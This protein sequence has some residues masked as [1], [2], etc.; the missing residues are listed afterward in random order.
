[1]PNRQTE[2]LGRESHRDVAPWHI[3]E[4]GT[5][6]S[7]S[8]FQ[9]T[10]NSWWSALLS[11]WAFLNWQA[12][13]SK[14][15]HLLHWVVKNLLFPPVRVGKLQILRHSKKPN[16]CTCRSRFR[17]LVKGELQ[18]DARENRLQ[19]LRQKRENFLFVVVGKMQMI[20]N[21]GT[22]DICHEIVRHQQHWPTKSLKPP[23][24]TSIHHPPVTFSKP[25][26][27]KSPSSTR[28]SPSQRCTFSV[29][30]TH[31]FRIVWRFHRLRLR[32]KGD[33]TAEFAAVTR[34]YELI[35]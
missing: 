11:F 33:K 32:W 31:D 20:S 1:M 8:D 17:N 4:P 34:S 35:N 10:G 12:K 18:G 23:L 22:L 27:L 25:L 7:F 9:S 24:C 19:H 3:R 29:K 21:L 2:S 13:S 5:D 6:L 14:S 16:I 26:R 15:S 28:G 30:K